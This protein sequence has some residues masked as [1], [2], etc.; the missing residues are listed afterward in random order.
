MP[1]GVLLLPLPG[2]YR[3]SWLICMSGSGCW[4]TQM[5]AGPAAAPLCISLHLPEASPLLFPMWRLQGTQT[6][7]L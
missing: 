4:K 1:Y 6:D 2:T 5:T 7:F 3:F